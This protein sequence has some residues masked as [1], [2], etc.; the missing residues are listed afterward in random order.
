LYDLSEK[1]NNQNAALKGK[2]LFVESAG[3]LLTLPE[4]KIAVIQGLDDYIIAESDNILL[5]CKKSDEQRIKQFVADVAMK[6]GEEY[7]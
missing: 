2:H 3:N 5:I 1:D 7:I 4:K 6:Y